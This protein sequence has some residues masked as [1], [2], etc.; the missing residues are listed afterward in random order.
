MIKL[1]MISDDFTGALDTGIQFAQY[2]ANTKIITTS[3]WDENLF[4]DNS[5]EVLVI[6]AQT[7]HLSGEEAYKKVYNLAKNAVSAGVPHIYKKTDSGLRGNIGSELKALLD[8]SDESFLPFIPA[9]P[10]MNRITMKGRH[11]I[12]GQPID[13]SV[14]GRDPF[15]PVASSEVKDLF[16]KE[17]TR[18]EI[19]ELNETYDLDFDTPAIGIFDAESEED[20]QRIAEYL[21]QKKH[22]RI[23]AGCAGL[24]YFLPELLEFKKRQITIPRLT[25]PLFV[26]CGSVNPISQEQIEYAQEQGFGRIMLKS[27][28]MFEPD[29]LSSENG[30]RW[31]ESIEDLFTKHPVVML[32]TGSEDLEPINNQGERTKNILH[33][34]RI[35]IASGLGGIVKKLLEINRNHTLMIIGG[36][37]LLGFFN[38]IQCSEVFPVCELDTGTVLSYINYENQKLWIIS[39]SG[40]FG[41]RELIYEIVRKLNL[42]G[43]VLCQNNICS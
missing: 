23:M 17:K 25:G 20:M 43:G 14:F 3:N 35:K 30:Y 9:Y 2:G 7:R 22:L 26:M 42:E 8:A 33:D 6:D 38:Q 24:A 11:Y 36:D 21:N 16:E 4:E 32:D 27:I 34:T 15:E 28:Q 40:G 39:K 5:A 18:V 29:Y 37:T 31:M 13:E 41:S 12:D 10:Q 1:L 19:L